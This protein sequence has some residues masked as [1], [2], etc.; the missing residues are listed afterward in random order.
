M[1]AEQAARLA[2]GAGNVRKRRPRKP[3]R[4]LNPAVLKQVAKQPEDHRRML[5]SGC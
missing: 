4:S 2:L 5:V 3:A 1:E